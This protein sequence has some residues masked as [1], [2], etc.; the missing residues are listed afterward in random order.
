MLQKHAVVSA[1]LPRT[2]ACL[3]H[4]VPLLL[5]D[6]RISDALCCSAVAEASHAS[7]SDAAKS[8]AAATA[9]KA[10]ASNGIPRKL[11]KAPSLRKQ[12]HVGSHLQQKQQQHQ[13]Q[14]QSQPSQTPEL[15]WYDEEM[16]VWSWRDDHGT[17]QARTAPAC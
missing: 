6:A 2:L 11:E 16:P 17:T 7:K 4:V 9:H 14:R 15:P 8:D 12:A 3:V 13:Q 10:S 5:Q 1:A